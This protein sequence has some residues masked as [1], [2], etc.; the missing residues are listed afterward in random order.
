MTAYSLPSTVHRIA[1]AQLRI[2]AA[3]ALLGEALSAGRTDLNA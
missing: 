3:A 1:D 2:N